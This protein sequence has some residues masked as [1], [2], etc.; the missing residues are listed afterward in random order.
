MKILHICQRDDPATGGALRVAEALIHEQRSAGLEVWL[1]FLYGPMDLIAARFAPQVHCLELQSSRQALKGIVAL[2]KVIKKVRPDIIHCHD[3]IMWPRLVL[4]QFRIPV[5]MH[6]HLPAQ[7]PDSIKRWLGWALVKKTTDSL[8]GISRHTINTWIKAGYPESRIHYVP[9]GV[10]FDRFAS[11]DEYTKI[12]IRKQL[13]LPAGKRILLWVGRLHRSMKGADRLEQMAW[14]LPEDTVLVVVGNGPEFSGMVGRCQNLIHAGRLV[15]AGAT[16][17]PEEYYKA[18]DAFLFT[19]YHEPF[20]LVILEAVASGLPILAFPLT[21]G[22]GAALLLE[23]FDALRIDDAVTAEEAASSLD[24]L[25]RRSGDGAA[26]REK[27]R[28]KYSWPELSGRLTE[29]YRTILNQPVQAPAPRI[30]H[31]CQR[32]DLSSGGATRIAFD[33]VVGQHRCG[34]RAHLLFLYGPPG[35]LGSL[36]SREETHYLGL[37]SGAEVLSKGWRIRRVLKEF[38]P[39]IVHHHDMLSWPQLFH[40]LPHRYHMVYHAHL[41]YRP[42]TT[43][44]ASIAAWLVRRNS[45]R[46][47]APS[48]FGRSRLIEARVRPQSV[49]VIPNGTN[50]PILQAVERNEVWLR[51]AHKIAAG[52]VVLGWGGRLHCEAKGTDDFIRL[53]CH[54]PESFI[55]IIAGQGPDEELLK[56]MVL[57]LGLKDRILFHGLE[58]NMERFYQGLDGFVLTSHFESFGLVVIEA[59]ANGVPVFSF[60]VEGGIADLLTLPGIMVVPERS[61]EA[62]GHQIQTFWNGSGFTLPNSRSGRDEVKAR[63]SIDRMASET[64]T[65]YESMKDA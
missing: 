32:D 48:A 35:E 51:D 42:Q 30:L 14:L 4:I 17:T 56:N 59:L 43:M 22:G 5:V 19:S 25:F 65:L 7:K 36:L 34:A 64:L 24:A 27:A 12:A 1:L 21:Q 53:F 8:I 46:I 31:I 58:K 3:G 33:L 37:S 26:L 57:Q 63:F 40:V 55:G 10:D 45:D 15:M 2:R 54:L 50:I 39:D 18:A 49:A 6:S 41:D 23:E 13:R 52:K 20:G 38:K 44:K 11:V 60:P 9:N 28:R 47:V 62:L 61:L 29:V 16:S